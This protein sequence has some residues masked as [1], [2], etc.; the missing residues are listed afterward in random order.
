MEHNQTLV[1]E[2][3]QKYLATESRINTADLYEAIKGQLN[4]ALELAEFRV[5]VGSWFKSG[6]LTR[7]ESVRGRFGGIRLLDEAARAARAVKP[8]DCE[9]LNDSAGSDNTNTEEVVEAE[10]SLIVYLSPS[11]RIHQPDTRNWAIQKKSGDMWISQYYQNSLSEIINSYIRHALN[12]EFR[13]SSDKITDLKEL[14]KLVKSI[15]TNLSNTLNNII[16]QK[17]SG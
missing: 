11:V 10:D 17:T 9:G 8:E 3:L 14:V 7:Y 2:Y 15:E 12:G 6:P 5:A 13:A 16:V 4:P 1:D